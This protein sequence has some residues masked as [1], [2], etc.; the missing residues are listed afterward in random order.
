LKDILIKEPIMTKE[1]YDYL[2]DSLRKKRVTFIFKKTFDILVS[3][4]MILA[5]SPVILILSILI[6]I[7]SGFPVFFRQE[8]MG[9]DGKTFRIFKFRTMKN[10][11]ATANGITLHNDI[12]ITRIGEFLRK[13]RLDEIPQLFNII[14]GEMSFVGPRP[15]LPKYYMV[16]DYGY[17]SVLLVRPGVTGEATLKF[18]DEDKILSISENPEKTYTEEIFPQKIRLNI[19]YIKRISILYDFK[20]MIHTFFSVFIKK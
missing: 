17:K 4:I 12:R 20:I 15:D 1:E 14:K 3:F 18:K 13:Y 6:V 11:T 8:R 19:D 16:D 5:L 7:D 2:V 10:N 9:K